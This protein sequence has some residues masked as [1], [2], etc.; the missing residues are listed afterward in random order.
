MAK[1]LAYLGPTG[2]FSEE[3]AVQ[4]DPDAEMVPHASIQAVALAVASGMADEGVVP[5]E[6]SLEG[7][8]TFTLD[9]LIQEDRL[10]IR[11]ELV[12]SIE[13]CLIVK[14][15]TKAGEIQAIYSH[16]QALGQCR[17][18]LE[19]CFPKAQQIAS[20][21]TAAAVDDVRGSSEDSAAI[22][23]RRAAELQ[24]MEILGE[25]IQDSSANVTRFVVLAH[26]DHP[27]TGKDKTSLCFSFQEDKPGALYNVLGIFA[28]RDINLTKVESRPSKQSLGDYIFL[29]DVHGH[30]EDPVIAAA[31]ETVRIHT[32]MLKVFGSYPRW[33]T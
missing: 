32:S 10:L 25:G 30:R 26:S 15:G 6:N 33:D 3:A 24:G 1:R 4:Y 23:P 7:S 17:S 22:A 29:I 20:L 18:F 11:R 2:T 9:T 14:P 27:R 31:I 28:H 8:V 5:I 16:P 21:S 13:H 12:L 19:R